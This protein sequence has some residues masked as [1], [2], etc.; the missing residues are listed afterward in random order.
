MKKGL[1]PDFLLVQ[2]VERPKSTAVCWRVTNKNEMRVELQKLLNTGKATD[3]L[4]RTPRGFTLSAFSASFSSLMPV[5]L[6]RIK[7]VAKALQQ[8]TDPTTVKGSLKPPQT[9]KTCPNM[10]PMITPMPKKLWTIKQKDPDTLLRLESNSLFTWATA[11][12]VLNTV[13]SNSVM[14]MAVNE[15]K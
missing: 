6:G 10:G 12:M 2:K 14:R 5:V 13:W 1:S 7:L 4:D 15:V 8:M 9:Y 11:K 3:G